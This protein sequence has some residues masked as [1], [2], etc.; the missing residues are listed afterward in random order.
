ML[1]FN[2]C[3]IT[4]ISKQTF[5]TNNTS[6]KIDNIYINHILHGSSWK[7]GEINQFSNK[8]TDNCLTTI[9]EK[10]EWCA[11]FDIIFGYRS[12]QNIT[13]KKVHELIY[14]KLKHENN[15][16]IGLDKI[17]KEFITTSNHSKYNIGDIL[18]DIHHDWLYL[19]HIDILL[20]HTL[21][22]IL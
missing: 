3:K 15:I 12:S 22:H 13:M 2:F 5:L 10:E 20:R 19:Q 18:E 9:T 4:I 7:G 11:N 6:T 16:S 8:Y 14:S 21:I 1:N 17:I